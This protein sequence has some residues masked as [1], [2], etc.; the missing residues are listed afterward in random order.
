MYGENC[1][2]RNYLFEYFAYTFV[3]MLFLLTNE[4][5]VIFGTGIVVF[6]HFVRIN[7]I[8]SNSWFFF[9]FFFEVFIDKIAKINLKLSIVVYD[10]PSYAI[11]DSIFHDISLF[12]K[13]FIFII[14]S[15]YVEVL[16]NKNNRFS[17]YVFKIVLLDHAIFYLVL[18]SAY[19][20]K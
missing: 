3:S 17:N 11:I 15:N 2:D 13:R 10:K 14:R 12:V 8:S 7:Q 5:L 16:L 19:L 9:F 1:L 20:F 18:I 4:K 6:K